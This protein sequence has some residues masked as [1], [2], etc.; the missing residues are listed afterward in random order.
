MKMIGR[1]LDCQRDYSSSPAFI[2]SFSFKL[3]RDARAGKRCHLMKQ[4][5]S[6]LDRFH[7]QRSPCSLAE[8]HAQVKDGA[9]AKRFEHQRMAALG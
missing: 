7:R 4:D 9:H 6:R 5:E 2:P 1:R 8:A 3:G